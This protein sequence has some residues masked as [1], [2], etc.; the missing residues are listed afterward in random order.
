[1]E[2]LGA[3]LGLKL[4]RKVIN[5]LNISIKEV[6]FGTDSMNVLG[7]IRQFSR[8]FKPFVANR[9]SSIQSET[10]TKQWN[11]VPTKENLADLVLR[12]TVSEKTGR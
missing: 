7:W 10:V 11:Y 4:A 1:M 8:L 6:Q 12:G 5:P 3:C 9:I 2:L